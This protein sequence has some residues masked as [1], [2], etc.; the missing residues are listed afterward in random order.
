M[1]E[2]TAD[3]TSML[4]TQQLQIIRQQFPK[5]TR[6]RLVNCNDPYT[7]LPPGLCGTVDSVDDAGTIHLNWD[8]GSNLGICLDDGDLVEII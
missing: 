2:P 3:I 7:R 1:P 6:V 8:N 4:R 5:D